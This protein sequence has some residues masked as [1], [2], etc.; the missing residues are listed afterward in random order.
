MSRKT[1][2]ICILVLLISLQVFSGCT[3]EKHGY[4][5]PGISH[6]EDSAAETDPVYTPQSLAETSLFSGFMVQDLKYTDSQGKNRTVPVA[7]WYP[8]RDRPKEYVYKNGIPTGLISLNGKPAENGPFPLIVFSHGYGG[9][10]IQSAFFTEALAQEG[11]VVAAPDHQ[12]AAF[13][14]IIPDNRSGIN[15]EYD[16]LQFTEPELITDTS[17][18]DRRDDVKAVIDRMLQQNADPSS[19][20]YQIIDPEQIGMC[21]HSLGGY[22][23]VAMAGGWQ[24]WRD[25]RIRAA[26]MFSPYIQPFLIHSDISAISIPLM[27]QGGTNDILITPS[28]Q[29]SNGGYDQANPPKFFL[30][31]RNAGHMDWSNSVCRKYNTFDDCVVSNEAAGAIT[32]YGIAFFNRYLKNDADAEIQL[33][34]KDPAVTD[35]RYAFG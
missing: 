26:L 27:F 33:G 35:L 10:G 25:E 1:A 23:T 19:V 8:T 31:I 34:M 7:I 3:T 16:L 24:S 14:S 15:Q 21:G 20:L 2:L 5:V 17:Y 28:I 11:Y 30:E 22:T 29:K 32:A 6:G 13:C 4:Q 18:L 12:D 9:C